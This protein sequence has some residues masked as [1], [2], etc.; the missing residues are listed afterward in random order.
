MHFLDQKKRTEQRGQVDTALKFHVDTFWGNLQ[1]AAL[2]DLDRL[3]GLVAWC[4]LSLLDLLDD[5]VALEDLA[6]DDV[7]AIEPAVQLLVSRSI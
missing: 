7:T 3:N 6:E 2:G 1:L 5:L 4:G